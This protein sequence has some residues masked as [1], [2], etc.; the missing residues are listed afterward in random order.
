MPPFHRNLSLCRLL[1]RKL[2]SVSVHCPREGGPLA[3]KMFRYPIY[4]IRYALAVPNYEPGI[5]EPVQNSCADAQFRHSYAVGN[6]YARHV[7]KRRHYVFLCVSSKQLQT[8]IRIVDLICKLA[9][10]KIC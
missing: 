10:F 5:K 9:G 8:V 6:E 4:E 2:E 3:A 1:A 7:Y